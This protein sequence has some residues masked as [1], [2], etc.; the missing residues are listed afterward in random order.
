MFG[1]GAGEIL[2]I[3]VFALIF[4]GPKKLPELAKN[5]GKSFREFQ[6]AKTD[7]LDEIENEPSSQKLT[8]VGTE[9]TV[10]PKSDNDTNTDKEA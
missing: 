8:G 10:V 2:I 7:F 4:I 1:L 6:R 3:L 9:N 5:L